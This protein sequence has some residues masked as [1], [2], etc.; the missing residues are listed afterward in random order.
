MKKV[1]SKVSDRILFGFVMCLLFI[2]L[3]TTPN[4]IGASHGVQ[5]SP[6]VSHT[7]EDMF[8]LS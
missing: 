5:P 4:D 1:F 3:E 7:E 6:I 8:D 2:P